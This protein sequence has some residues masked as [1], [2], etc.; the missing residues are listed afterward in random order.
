MKDPGEIWREYQWMIVGVLAVV[1]CLLGVI[2]F[3]RYFA[4][5]MPEATWFD[6]V[7]Y[8]LQLFSLESGSFTG[9]VPWQLQVARFLAPGVIVYTAINALLVVFR[10]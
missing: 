7:Y 3:T 4:V 9:E 5:H 6:S 10:D 1:A 2:G 8:T